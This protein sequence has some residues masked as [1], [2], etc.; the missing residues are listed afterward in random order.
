MSNKYSLK[1]YYTLALLS[2]FIALIC[3]GNSSYIYVKASLAQILI[4][5]SW[6]KLTQDYNLNAAKPWPWADTYPVAKLY[7]DKQTLYVLNSISG[8]SLSFGPGH[9]EQTVLPGTK[10]DSIVAGHRDTHFYF[11]Q[12]MQLGD[13]IKAENY[14]GEEQK[15]Q[16]QNIKIVDSSKEQVDISPSKNRLQLITCYP[17]NAIVAGGPLRYIVT[18]TFI[19]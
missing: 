2:L 16:V 5:H 13:I 14:L 3:L 4:H 1:A 18:A 7:T 8:E 10:G 15:Y 19:N 12:D 9:Y 11:L 6:Q 17:F